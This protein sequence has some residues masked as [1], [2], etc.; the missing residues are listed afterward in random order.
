MAGRETASDLPPRIVHTPDLTFLLRYAFPGRS[1]DL[2]RSKSD[3]GQQWDPLRDTHRGRLGA[4]WA[5][6]AAGVRYRRYIIR[7]KP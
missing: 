5:Y 2:I 4:E 7:L 6:D 3:S 1:G